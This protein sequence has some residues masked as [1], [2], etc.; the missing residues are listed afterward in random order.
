MSDDG[1]VTHHS[2]DGEYDDE[3]DAITDRAR[4]VIVD[5]FSDR[6]LSEEQL[7][8]LVIV[9]SVSEIPPEATPSQREAVINASGESDGMLVNHAMNVLNALVEAAG[10]K[11]ITGN[12]RPAHKA[13]EHSVDHGDD[14]LA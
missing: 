12:A 2:P 6:G 1:R 10:G 3:L 9:V 13:G 11:L 7:N 5:G 14:P 4:D 8:K